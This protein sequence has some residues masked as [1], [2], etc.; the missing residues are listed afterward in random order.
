MRLPAPPSEL[1]ETQHPLCVDNPKA[2][3]RTAA[4]A[5]DARLTRVAKIM[6]APGFFAKDFECSR[7][8]VRS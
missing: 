8:I 1:D 7:F 2:G 6:Q 4:S 5:L 3:E